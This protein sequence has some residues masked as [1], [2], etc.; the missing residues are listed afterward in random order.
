MPKFKP[1]D[2]VSVLNETIRG[3]VISEEGN[4]VRIE[5]TD[6]FERKYEPDEL[7]HSHQDDY[8]FDDLDEEEMIADQLKSIRKE[9]FEKTSGLNKSY[10]IDLHIEVLVDDHNNMTNFEIVQTQMEYC[11]NF[12]RNAL[13]S[14]RKKVYIIHGKGQG[15]LK[16]EV[17]TFLR[18][19]RLENGVELDYHD[20]PYPDFGKGGAT[21]VIFL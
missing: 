9:R 7:V 10:Y 5:D 21:E 14:N 1:G 13:E 11:K 2:Q 16:A 20:A 6:G 19:L 4:V 17:H 3:V 18:N 12:I 8:N 15:V